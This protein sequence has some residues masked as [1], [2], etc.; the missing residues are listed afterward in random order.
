MH[1]MSAAYLA[2]E[3]EMEYLSSDGYVFYRTVCKGFMDLD[4]QAGIFLHSAVIDPAVYRRS[5]RAI[6]G[7]VRR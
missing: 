4:R 2:E 1:C 6:P 7:A 3:L 5:D